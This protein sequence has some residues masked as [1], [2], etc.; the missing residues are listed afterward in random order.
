MLVKAVPI[1]VRLT[2]FSAEYIASLIS[3]SIGSLAAIE[4]FSGLSGLL[5]GWLS[6]Y[7]FNSSALLMILPPP[8][9]AKEKPI[10]ATR[11]I[12]QT[13]RFCVPINFIVFFTKVLLFL[14]KN[15]LHNG[16]S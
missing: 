7:A 9:A 1:R 16:I 8:Q 5:A 3:G 12:A 14:E 10:A 6:R 15:T 11:A 13:L 4:I 2:Y